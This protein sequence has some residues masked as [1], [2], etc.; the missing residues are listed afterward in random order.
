MNNYDN[1]LIYNGENITD[2]NIKYSVTKSIENLFNSCKSIY[3]HKIYRSPH[4]IWFILS[5]NIP[6]SVIVTILQNIMTK[7]YN[8]I[9]LKIELKNNPLIL[10]NIT[11]PISTNLTSGI[12]FPMINNN[13]YNI[14]DIIINTEY[15]PTSEIFDILE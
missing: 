15:N 2:V 4:C 12:L 10:Q 3:D 6:D 11:I 1:V 7:A 5:K 13:L 14:A 8:S 9:L